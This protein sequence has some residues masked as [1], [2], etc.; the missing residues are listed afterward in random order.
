[1][2]ELC[3]EGIISRKSYDEIPLYVEYYPT[4]KGLALRPILEEVMHWVDEY[5]VE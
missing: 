1:L 5:A 2:D 4:E 3:A